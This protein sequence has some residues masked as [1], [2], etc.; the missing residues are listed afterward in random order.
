VGSVELAERLDPD[1]L[2]DVLKAYHRRATEIVEA[3]GGVVAQYQGDGIL[4]YFGY[5]VASED[6]AERAIRA[7]LN[8]ANIFES[9]PAL[10]KLRL[11]VGIATGMAVVGELAAAAMADQPPIVG[12][13]PNLAA[14]LQSIAEPNTVIIAPS[15]KRLAGGLFEYADLG[16]QHLKGFS[17]PIRAWQVLGETVAASRFEALRS[18]H[19]PLV[20]REEE[21][22]LLLGHWARAKRGKGQVVLITG[23]AGMGKSRLTLALQE[24]LTAETHTHLIYHGSP[25]HRDSAFYPVISQL[26]RAAGI[27]REDSADQKLAKL[28]SLF[29]PTT[30]NPKEAVSLLAPLLSIP[31]GSQY[32]ALDLTPQRRKDRTFGALL[33]QLEILATRQPVL[34]VSED[35]HWFDPT[36]LELF[37]LVLDRIASLPVLMIMT[38]R[39]EFSPPWPSHTYDSTVMLNRL[40]QDEIKKVA[41][42][43]AKGKALPLEVLEQILA[44]SDGVPLFV[45]ELTK[46][47]LESRL[48]DDAGDRYLLRNPLP[49]L[50][51]PSTLHASLLA[52]LDRL[53]AVKDVAQMASAIGREFSYSLIAAVA[54]LSEQDLQGALEQLVAAEL[55]FQ[56]GLPPD[57]TYLFKHALV[58]DA[59]Y[60]S[61]IRSRRYQI[62]AQIAHVLEDQFPDVA[63]SEPETLAQ[64]FTAAGLIERGVHYWIQAGQHAC[65][66]SAFVEATRHFNT[67]IE[68]LKTLPETPARTQQELALY[69]GLGR[70]LIVTK[71][72]PSV[73]VE[74]AYLT[75]HALCLQMG[76]TPELARVLLGLWRCYISQSQLRKA[77]E[78]G[79]SLLRLSHHTNDPAQAV[80]S[81]VALGHCEL[82]LAELSNARQHLEEGISRYAP[83]QRRTEVFRDAQDP[84]VS[85]L[86]YSALS[87]WLLGFSDQAHTRSRDSLALAHELKHPFSVAFAQCCFAFLSQFRRD[88]PN[89]REQADAA[90]A[91]STEHGFSVFVAIA[92]P[93]CGWASAMEGKPEKGVVELQQ[94]IAAMRAIRAGIWH[95]F[96]CSMLAE[97]FDLVGNAR[98]GL[99]CLA[100]AQTLM[101]QTGERWWEAEIYRLQG[102]LLLRYSMAPPAEVE[103]W[104]RRALDVA[105][106]QDA[107]SLELR[108]ATSLARLWDHQG[109]HTQARDLLAPI[110][111]KFTEGFDTFDLKEA[112]ALLEEQ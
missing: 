51:I 6:D 29:T 2:H 34:I 77:R 13:T 18:T 86:S 100:E 78:L 12:G 84:G 112:K 92:T 46:T 9:S 103:T 11:R 79:E 106:R 59:V 1:T 74:Q 62:E 54:R 30:G 111:D 23:E 47:V 83:E 21:V 64:H 66:R 39:P 27:E 69:M 109:Q 45:E 10:E 50:A 43:T 19:M 17:Q 89:V 42:N 101:D 4:A 104:F 70:A 99:Q 105:R 56:R 107:R 26:V 33:D 16:P 76:E 110:Y 3:A 94:G 61:L 81:R 65:D 52:R 93:F 97:A 91:L 20:G 68:L 38:A 48:L 82:L 72:Q 7:G 71:G 35:A 88:V 15:T 36:T 85:C 90:V 80:V 55:I 96:R 44:H 63:A 60:A 75:A 98:E 28:E 41:F 57:A 5:P 14:R 58:Q 37:L 24:R 102:T 22:E 53:A 87:L 25:H 8:L 49:S 67:G 108:A 31:L 40:G 32:A 95:P 73:E